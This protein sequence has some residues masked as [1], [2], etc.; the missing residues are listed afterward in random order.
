MWFAQKDAYESNPKRRISFRSADEK[1]KDRTDDMQEHHRQHPTDFFTVGQTSILD[2]VN[3]HPDPKDE[4][5]Q[6]N[7]SHEHHDK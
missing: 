5:Q 3:D 4:H 7:G 2:G 1:I 6:A